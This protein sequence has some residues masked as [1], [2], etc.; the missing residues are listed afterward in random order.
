MRLAIRIAGVVALWLAFGAAFAQR[1]EGDR[2]GAHGMYEAEVNVNGQGETERNTAFARAMSQVL[3]KLSGN[4]SAASMPGVG[5]ELRRA[6]DYVKSYDYRQD[7]GRSATGA[8][9]YTTTLIVRFD[10]EQVDGIAATLGLPIW[11]EPRP[12]PV[13]W[14]AINDGRGPR[15]VALAQ[16]GAARAVLDRAQERGY[17]LGLPSGSAA[18]QAAVGAIW[19]GDTAAIARLSSRYSPPMQLIG[20]LYRAEGGGWTAD[21]TFVDSGKVLSTWTSTQPDARRAM[22]SGADG[23]ADALSKKYAKR[24]SAAGTAGRYTVQID[25]VRDSEDYL[26]LMSYL[27]SL[28]VVRGMAPVRANA[29]GLTLELDLITGLPGLKRALG[30]GEVL[31]ADEGDAP[32][33]HLR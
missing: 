25:G 4:R 7:E 23:A 30:N 15:L 2:A 11:A 5:Q 20:K 1:V 22:A 24:S 14:L 32:V 13:L 6:R 26:R 33:L 8:P 16:T 17:R 19:R 9:T 12:K 18:E 21:W 27:Q 31:T 28:A 10:Q 29:E 3:G